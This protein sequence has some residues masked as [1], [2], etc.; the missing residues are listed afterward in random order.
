MSTE[1]PEQILAAAD[2]AVGEADAQ[3]AELEQ[4]VI[5]GDDQVGP[6]DIEEARS[7]RYFAGLARRRAEKK[8]AA[9]RE[10]QARQA[11]T[12]AI[13]EA[14]KILDEVPQ[15][16]VDQAQQAAADAMRTLRTVVRARN[17][18]RDRALAVLRAC[19]AIET[20]SRPAG[21]I[22]GQA[23]WRGPDFG[24]VHSDGYGGGF[25]LWID[26]R[27]VDVLDEHYLLDQ[28]RKAP[29]RA[30]H[31]TAQTEAAEAKARR[32]EQ[33]A[34]LFRADP[35]AFAELPAV[36]RRPAVEKAGVTWESYLSDPT[37]P[38]PRANS[39]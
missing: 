36:R 21:H 30:D 24:V 7:R 13:L 12:V 26:G 18:A 3:L 35:H 6:D 37:R 4:K 28:A 25:G 10:A 22:R 1:T 27:P 9:L 39:I 5:D 19:P 8:A 20:V 11:R 29:D 2:T 17:A 23:P 38:R 34:V 32:I 31:V 16:D 33:D 15:A 14:R